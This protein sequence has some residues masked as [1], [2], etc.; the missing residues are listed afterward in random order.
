MG[1]QKAREALDAAKSDFRSA[2]REGLDE[3]TKTGLEGLDIKHH[4]AKMGIMP[5]KI[6]ESREIPVVVENKALLDYEPLSGMK[7]YREAQIMNEKLG[8]GKVEDRSQLTTHKKH[9]HVKQVLYPETDGLVP[10]RRPK[11]YDRQHQF[12]DK[13]ERVADLLMNDDQR[14]EAE[15]K[16]AKE[17]KENANDYLKRTIYREESDDEEVLAP[18]E[19]YLDKPRAEVREGDEEFNFRRVKIPDRQL[20]GRS[21]DELN[22]RRDGLRKR[23]KRV[24]GRATDGGYVVTKEDE[25]LRLQR[26]NLFE[27]EGGADFS[28]VK[29]SAWRSLEQKYK[30]ISESEEEEE[31]KKPRKNPYLD[32][33]SGD[34]DELYGIPKQK[35]RVEKYDARMKRRELSPEPEYMKT[36]RRRYDADFD[37]LEK[38]ISSVKKIRK[39]TSKS[40]YGRSPSISPERFKPT[41][42]EYQGDISEGVSFTAKRLKSKT[43]G[44]L[45]TSQPAPSIQYMPEFQLRLRKKTF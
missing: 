23:T 2:R 40:A 8:T 43:T 39:S 44:E 1:P 17:L 7:W 15:R 32:D 24:E 21:L 16:K 4:K 31:V 28:R 45:Y 10:A 35:T 12:R 36:T 37:E 9:H 14:E 38:E 41:R 19:Q 26:S 42:G 33:L 6:P 13:I 18:M 5:Y 29:G 11:N 3:E 20:A 34:S 22:E 25:M 30:P 27:Y